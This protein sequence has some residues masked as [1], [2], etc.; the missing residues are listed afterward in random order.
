MSKGHTFD[1]LIPL[2]MFHFKS[3]FST[4]YFVLIP[5]SKKRRFT[6]I[7]DLK[8]KTEVLMI[9]FENVKRA[10]LFVFVAP[11][12]WIWYA[13][14]LHFNL[15]IWRVSLEIVCQESQ[16]STCTQ[17]WFWFDSCSSFT[18][19]LSLTLEISVRNAHFQVDTHLLRRNAKKWW[20]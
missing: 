12:F 13:P 8:K 10:N 2:S 9:F 20:Y 6:S 15:L 3:Y 7:E 18:S 14:G 16:L 11:F 5:L 17:N 1:I 4:T 19:S